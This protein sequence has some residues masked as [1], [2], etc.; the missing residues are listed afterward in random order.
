[1][2]LDAR[3]RGSSP[4]LPMGG[5]FEDTLEGVFGTALERVADLANDVGRA[6]EANGEVG[7]G[8]AAFRRALFAFWPR[9]FSSSSEEVASEFFALKSMLIATESK[10]LRELPNEGARLMPGVRSDDAVNVS[11][12]RTRRGITMG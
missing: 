4:L 6:E 3:V 5:V 9:N 11:E 10:L 12:R 1:M 8:E 7:T 2:D